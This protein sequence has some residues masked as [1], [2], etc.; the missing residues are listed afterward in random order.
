MT[1]T[2]PPIQEVDQHGKQL[3]R[4]ALGGYR[5]VRLRWRVLFALVDAIGSALSAAA[6]LLAGSRNRSSALD[7][8]RRILVVQFDHLGDA[9]L[10]T[11]IFA[12]LRKR[13]PQARIDVLAAPWNRAV[14]DSAAEVDNVHVCRRNRFAPN[15]GLAWIPAT[16]VWG[17]RL[18]KHRYDL[19]IDVRG[20][21]PHNVLLWLSG[22]ARRLGWAS[23]GGGFLLTDKPDYVADPPGTAVASRPAQV[24]RHRL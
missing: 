10:T 5:Y 12:P 20:E 7:D 21:F 8:P 6:R 11:S 22:A 3:R 18:R 24:P 14:F 4:R 19:A 2:M 23:G 9:I 1:P 17:L 16:I 15:V 13:F